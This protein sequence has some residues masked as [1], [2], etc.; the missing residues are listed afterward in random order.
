[1]LG[2]RRLCT[3]SIHRPGKSV[4]A[5]TFSGLISH[6]VSKRPIWLAEAAAHW[7]QRIARVTGLLGVIHVLIAG[8]ASEHRLAQ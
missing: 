3:L 6:S 7:A 2:G 8:Q 4:R 1:M 5:L